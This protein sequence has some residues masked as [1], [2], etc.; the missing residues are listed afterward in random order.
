MDIQTL[1]YILALEKTRNFSEAAA[2]CDI[3]QSSFSKHIQ[4]AEDELNGVRLFDRTSRPLKVTAAGREFTSYARQI[5]EEYDLLEK[6]M[7]QYDP[8]YQKE[9]VVGSI[10]VMGAL[11]ISRLIHTFRSELKPDEKISI[12]DLPNK[13]L[14]RDLHCG[15]IDLA[16]LVRPVEKQR[17]TDLTYYRLKDYELYLVT[18]PSDPLVKA[19]VADWSDLAQRTFISQDEN[20]QIYSLF[21]AAFERHGLTWSDVATLRSLSSIVE[22]VEAGYGVT[23]LSQPAYASFKGHNIKAVKMKDPLYFTLTIACY[24]RNGIKPLAKRFVDKALEWEFA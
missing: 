15:A 2:L 20:T 7:L 13:E 22:N 21:R 19:G 6:A 14:I 24:S 10:P 8:R 11:G 1:R 4:K 17:T 12:K 18:N 9:L 5:V 23:M 3:S 16:F